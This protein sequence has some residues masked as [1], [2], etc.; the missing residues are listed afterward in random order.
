MRCD[1]QCHTT[2]RQHRPGPAPVTL[3]L[4]QQCVVPPP[5]QTL[6]E[7]MKTLFVHFK[8]PTMCVH[9]L[10]CDMMKPLCWPGGK[11]TE[12]HMAAIQTWSPVLPLGS[13]GSTLLPL[14]FPTRQHRVFFAGGCKWKAKCFLRFVLE[15]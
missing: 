1:A 11:I 4:Q 2:G 10:N 12:K 7:F 6:D 3:V 8:G 5:L 15:S 9:R 13:R 14:F